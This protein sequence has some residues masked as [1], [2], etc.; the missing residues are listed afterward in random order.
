M[1]IHDHGVLDLETPRDLTQK[2]RDLLTAMVE[3]AR[4]ECRDDLRRQAMTAK[5]AAE[6]KLRCGSIVL[7]VDR[8][9]CGPAM[10]CQ[11]GVPSTAEGAD[12]DGARLSVLL[13]MREGYIRMIECYRADGEP[14]HGL[15]LASSVAYLGG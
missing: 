7:W 9:R 12:T 14:A 6:C 2:E 15:P 3:S 8:D 13:H 4:A 5:V 1:T 10:A 11:Q